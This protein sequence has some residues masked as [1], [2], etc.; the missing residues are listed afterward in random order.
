MPGAVGPESVLA[1]GRGRRRCG[2]SCQFARGGGRATG[3][4]DTDPGRRTVPRPTTVRQPYAE[5][6]RMAVS[7]L[8]RAAGAPQCE[9]SAMELA[10]HLVLRDSTGP[11]SRVRPLPRP[12]AGSGCLD[13]TNDGAGP[14][15]RACRV[16]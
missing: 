13:E 6:G 12:A 1:P 11:A 7:R 16:R 2:P 15:P 3:F 10:T 9:H 8:M 5:M 14:W 4:D